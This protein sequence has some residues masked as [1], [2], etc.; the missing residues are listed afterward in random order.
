[1]RKKGE[2]QKECFHP[3]L[4]EGCDSTT[5]DRNP[6]PVR[7]SIP[8]AP[9]SPRLHRLAVAASLLAG[10]ATTH[11]LC[12]SAAAAPRVIR[13]IR[14]QRDPIFDASDYARLPDWPLKAMNALHVDTREGFLRRELTFAV[15]D[16][17]D[18]EDLRESER[19]LRALGFLRSADLEVVSSRGDSVD[20]FVHT[21]E[22]WTT[23]LGIK[24][25]SYQGSTFFGVNLTERNLMGMGRSLSGRYDTDP[26]RSGWSV[27]YTHPYLL[28]T[29]NR[30][31]LRFS[32][33]SDGS[34]AF[35]QLGRPWTSIDAAS[36]YDLRWTHSKQRPRY[37]IDQIHYLRPRLDDDTF[38]AGFLGRIGLSKHDVFRLG[39]KL[40]WERLR[41]HQEDSLAVSTTHQISSRTVDFPPDAPENREM[42]ALGV[43][44]EW[45]T[46]DYE[47]LHYVDLMGRAED[48]AM[49]HETAVGAGWA[50][51]SLVGDVDAVYLEL[52]HR[53]NS[54]HGR[55]LHRLVWTGSGLIEDGRGRNLRTVLDYR[56][57]VEIQSSL[58]LVT[59]LRGGWGERLDAQRPFTMGSESGL[60]SA[61][62]RE[63]TGDRL[64]RANIELR[65]VKQQA[66]LNLV[67]P[68]MVAFADFGNTWFERESDFRWDGIHGAVGFGLRIAAQMSTFGYPVRLDVAW[69]V[70]KGTGASSPVFTVGT[71]HAF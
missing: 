59:G 24:F 70:A 16:T 63:F 33:T 23:S 26:D 48:L 39:P 27:E 13:S 49:G 22:T 51:G 29:E 19:R 52:D 6:E 34:L 50:T 12:L 64:V 45:K 61:G 17:L 2:E 32:D 56:T 65:W 8:M 5:F 35:I 55:L 11:L 36:S 25:S 3:P 53:Y 43:S 4:R 69:P 14:F 10:I 37:S 60:R 38:F 42:L 40:W 46:R 57:Q 9:S 44:L 30:L 7:P 62:Y 58:R 66:L 21:R 18:L 20:V 71:G 15:G 68:G 47:T 41:F 54:H 1:M 28:G 31:A 67:I